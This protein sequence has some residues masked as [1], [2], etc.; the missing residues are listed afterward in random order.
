MNSPPHP[1]TIIREQAEI[2]M[3][4]VS[5]NGSLADE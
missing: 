1:E 5:F 2:G 3:D 4:T